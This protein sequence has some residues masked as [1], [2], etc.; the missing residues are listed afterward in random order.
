MTDWGGGPVRCGPDWFL[1]VK[2]LEQGYVFLERRG[3]HFSVLGRV[4]RPGITGGSSIWF[5]L[6]YY[7]DRKELQEIGER[8]QLCHC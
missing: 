6:F 1:D 8:L 4:A 7:C 3:G 5:L 2:E